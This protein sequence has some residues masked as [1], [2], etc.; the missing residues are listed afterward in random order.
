M[1]DAVIP[2]EP[3]PGPDTQHRAVHGSLT[4][5]AWRTGRATVVDVTGQVDSFTAPHLDDVVNAVPQETPAIAVI[6]LSGVEFLSVAGV[7]VLMQAHERAEPGTV[8]LVATGHAVLRALHM[9]GLDSSLAIY[10]SR[11]AALSE[12]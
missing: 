7:T 5:T 6:D 1:T 4:A 9:T 12:D 2:Q 3:T 8:R 10:P 11:A